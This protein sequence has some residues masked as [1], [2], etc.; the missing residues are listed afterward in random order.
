[1]KSID[2][3]IFRL[4]WPNIISNVSIPLLSSVDTA[5]MGY[6]STEHLG[7][8]GLGSMIFNFFYWNFGFLRMGTTGMTAQAYGAQDRTGIANFFYRGLMVST[9]IAAALILLQLPIVHGGVTLLNAPSGQADLIREYVMIRV[10]A[11]PATLGL[12][13]LM[14]WLF[15]MQNALL[16]MVVTIL[17]NV[18]NIVLSYIL[19]VNYGLGIAGVAWGTVVAQYI[20]CS[21]ILLA[22]VR[23]YGD[24]IQWTSWATVLKLEEVKRFFVINRDIFVRTLCLTFAFGFFYSRSAVYGEVLLGVN[25]VLLQFL[26]WMSYGIDGLAFAAES[27]VGRHL[28]AKHYDLLTRTVRRIFLWAFL[29]ALAFSALYWLA[30]PWIFRLFTDVEEVLAAFGPYLF[31]MALLPVFGFASYIWDG[32]YVGLTASRAMRNSMVLSLGGYFILYYALEPLLG[33][34][35]LW[36]SLSGF[37]FLRGVIQHILYMRRGWELQ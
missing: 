32:I 29:M 4:A 3:S 13:V 34:N 21:V 10:W 11:A 6:L 30:G 14:G 20:G 27:L 12:Y 36:L 28:G 17:I 35:A 22:I 9:L 16:P 37:L 2:R 1:M 24:R 8:V 15:G 7:A 19:I 26:N 23:R 31:W 33:I 25:I 18:V 5:L